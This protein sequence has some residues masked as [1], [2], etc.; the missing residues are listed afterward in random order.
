MGMNVAAGLV[1]LLAAD[2]IMEYIIRRREGR[3]P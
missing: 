1:V 2:A 3:R